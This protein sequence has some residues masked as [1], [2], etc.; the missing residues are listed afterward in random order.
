MILAAVSRH[1][2]KIDKKCCSVEKDPIMERCQISAMKQFTSIRIHV[3]ILSFIEICKTDV[4]KTE[5]NSAPGDV[6]LKIL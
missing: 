2:P 6:L 4:T 5:R 1:G 3:F